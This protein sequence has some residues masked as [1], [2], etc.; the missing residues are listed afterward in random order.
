MIKVVYHSS[1]EALA[2][3]ITHDLQEQG[4]PVGADAAERE[5]AVIIVLS[6]E[7]VDDQQVQDEM[8]DALDASQQILPVLAQPVKLPKLINHLGAVDFSTGYNFAT[9]R[10]RLDPLLAPDAHLPLKVLTPTVKRANRSSGIVL[11]LI[12]L[13]MF[14]VGL[15]GVGVLHIQ[16]PASV[17]TEQDT[18]DA[19]TRDVL[20]APVMQYYSQFLPKGTQAPTDYP[21]TVR[22][23]P[24]LYR[25]FIAQTSTAIVATPVPP[26]EDTSNIGF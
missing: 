18:Q 1:D 8:I 15:Y 10:H 2:Q 3:Q 9:L 16:A 6:P 25:Q 26:T 20:L 17:F 23:V 12:A 14:A 13:T 22:A 24:T 4:Y 5:D 11:G 7:A 19:M 21:A